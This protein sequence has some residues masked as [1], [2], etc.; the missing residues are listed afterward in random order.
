[1]AKAIA[2]RWSPR[3]SATP[4]PFGAA[5]R[6]PTTKPSGRS[7]ASRPMRAEPGDER[8]D[9]IALLDAQFGRAADGDASR[10][11]RRAPRLPAIRRSGLEFR[12][13][14]SRPVGRAGAATDTV[15]RGSPPSVA[16]VSTST[17]AP[18]RRSTSSSAV[19]VG[20]R[21][22]CSISMRDPGMAAAA[23]SQKAA[24]EKSPGTES[25]RAVRRWPPETDTVR[26]RRPSTS[27]P[28]AS[29]RPL[30]VIA[31]RRRFD[32]AGRSVGMEPG[33]EHGALHLCARDL[34]LVGN[35]LQPRA[36]NRERGVAVGGLDARAHVLE[37]LDDPTHGPAGKRARR[38]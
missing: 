1:M 16:I 30:G 7:S 15:P 38:R 36:V 19:R 10:R 24:D 21:P 17:R 33:E 31:G 14:R 35:G 5:S 28:K 22:T 20:L 11:G 12:R 6:P 9:A 37:R 34:G 13:A 25:F 2:I 3:A 8:G 4:P 26:P 18:N 32:D 29:E 23:T 27:P